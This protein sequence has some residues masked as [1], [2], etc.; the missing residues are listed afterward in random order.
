[1]KRFVRTTLLGGVIV[2]LPVGILVAVFGWLWA[3]ATVT[4]FV[5]NTWLTKALWWKL[6]VGAVAG[7]LGRYG[8]MGGGAF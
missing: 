5:T 4:L 8:P 2:L 3:F 6:G 7:G 1:M